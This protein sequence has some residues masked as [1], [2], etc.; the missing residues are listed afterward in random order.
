MKFTATIY[1]RGKRIDRFLLSHLGDEYS[2]R[3]LQHAVNKGFILVNGE[4]VSSRL[5]LL[6]GD[7][8]VVDE[9]VL[10]ASNEAP[11]K[12]VRDF[13]EPKVFYDCDEYV[14]IEKP[15]GMVVHPNK[16]GEVGTLADWLLETF[17]LIRGVGEDEKRPGM[18]HRLDKDVSGLM[19]IAKTQKSYEYLKNQ[20]QT[21]KVKKIY[22]ALLHGKLQK[23]EGVIDRPIGRSSH[24][25]RMAA[26]SQKSE[27]KSASTHYWV[28][29]HLGKT[30][31]E[32]HGYSLL[33][34]EITTG[35]THQ[36]RAHMH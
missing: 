13:G 16:E 14:I 32:H 19:V 34:V 11:E 29:E 8:V 36:I 33:E 5:L 2:R 27:G 23:Q 20:F 24:G 21:H 3:F 6:E 18:M 31:G 17:P 30:A 1:D 12:I 10:K 28:L 4:V 15:A 25:H 26:K 35:R 9:K 7:E 22:T